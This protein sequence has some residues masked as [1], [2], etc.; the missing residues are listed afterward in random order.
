M[1]YAVDWRPAAERELAQLWVD[2]PADRNAITVATAALEARLRLDPLA[3]GESRGGVS[4][5]AFEGPLGIVFDVLVLQRQ[6]HVNRIW[7]PH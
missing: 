7:K 6:V 5:M 2:H 4:R 1:S 3:L